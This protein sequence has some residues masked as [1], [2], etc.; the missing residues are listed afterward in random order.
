MFKQKSISLVL[1]ILFLSL[2]V[3]AQIVPDDATKVTPILVNSTIPDVSVKTIDGEKAALRTV[4]AEKPTIL[5]FYRGGW[6]PYC[7]RHMAEL[8][9]IESQ[10][11]ELGYQILAISV[12]K[13]E[14]LRETLTKGELSYSLLSDSPA[15]VMKAFGI[16]YR[17]D[18]K[19]VARY[20]SV[21]I[22]FEKNTGYDHHILPAPAVFIIDQEGTVKFQYVNPDYKERI[23][24][25]VLLTAAKAYL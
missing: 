19:T 14:V 24:G 9:K 7:S 18:D 10:I 8:Q 6:C 11:V 25:D 5:I 20:K 22:D 23:N 2:P 15:D 13:P 16:A 17:V 1:F 3:S 21:G 12:D 4:V